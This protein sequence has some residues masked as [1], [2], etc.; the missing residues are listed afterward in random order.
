MGGLTTTEEMLK[1]LSIQIRMTAYCA[2]DCSNHL[3]IHSTPEL[4]DLLNRAAL[5]LNEIAIAVR[6]VG[7][8]HDRSRPAQT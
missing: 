1:A 2:V 7:E 6:G 8:A 5:S 3:A 4:A